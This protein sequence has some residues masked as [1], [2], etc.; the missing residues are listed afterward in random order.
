[1]SI[2]SS[3]SL[4]KLIEIIETSTSGKGTLIKLLEVNRSL[5]NYQISLHI[6]VYNMYKIQ[7]S[8]H[9]NYFIINAEGNY[10]TIIFK[11]NIIITCI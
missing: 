4:S 10:L 11:T 3:N 2:F 6:Y 9:N 7:F 5:I 1:M 8:E